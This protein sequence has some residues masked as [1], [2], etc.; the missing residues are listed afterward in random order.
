MDIDIRIL[1]NFLNNYSLAELNQKKKKRGV[2]CKNATMK[3]I[4]KFT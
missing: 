4:P 1:F 3:N 2:F